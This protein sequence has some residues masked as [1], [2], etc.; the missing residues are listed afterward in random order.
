MVGG[1]T[2]VLSV[3]VNQEGCF[4]IPFED[5]E[6][7]EV[8]EG[9]EEKEEKEEKE[10]EEEEEAGGCIHTLISDVLFFHFSSWWFIL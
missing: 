6:E 9:E 2:A 7:L 10:E 4:Q 1:S 3:M 8:E 5:V